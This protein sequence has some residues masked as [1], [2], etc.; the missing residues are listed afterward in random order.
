[1]AGCVSVTRLEMAKNGFKALE[2]VV[3]VVVRVI[4][5]LSWPLE[6]TRF[7]TPKQ[8]K[9]TSVSDLQMINPPGGTLIYLLD[10]AVPRGL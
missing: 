7:G 4:V 6:V 10:N 3:V 1:M 5:L 8:I 9:S 2:I